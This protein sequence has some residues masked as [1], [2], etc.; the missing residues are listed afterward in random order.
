MEAI[1]EQ[2][3]DHARIIA[4]R[5]GDGLGSGEDG[6]SLIEQARLAFHWLIRFEA[7]SVA[8]QVSESGMRLQGAGPP[9]NA[10]DLQDAGG[11]IRLD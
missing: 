3:P 6:K 4:G 9:E 1:G 7:I 5:I 10:I 11:V 2:P 8:N